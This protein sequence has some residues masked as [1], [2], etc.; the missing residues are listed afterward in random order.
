MAEFSRKQQIEISA[1]LHCMI[2]NQLHHSIRDAERAGDLAVVCLRN[3]GL[4]PVLGGSLTDGEGQVFDNC[5]APVILYD[6]S[7][8]DRREFVFDLLLECL[9]V[10]EFGE[11]VETLTT[12]QVQRYHITE[13]GA[14][15]KSSEG[16]ADEP[17][18]L[19]DYVDFGDIVSKTCFSGEDTAGALALLYADGRIGD[20]DDFMGSAIDLQSLGRE[21]VRGFLDQ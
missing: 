18:K 5:E 15:F 3:Y 13:R 20:I 11:P 1:K 2:L 4:M 8:G 9:S 7:H 17:L 14:R 12:D 16:L 10:N 21:P 6:R 19:D